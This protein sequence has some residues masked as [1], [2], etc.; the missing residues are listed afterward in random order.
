MHQ[1]LCTY[2][3]KK[4]LPIRDVDLSSESSRAL[5]NTSVCEYNSMSMLVHKLRMQNALQ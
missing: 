5:Q 1:S 3:R 4:F 2:V